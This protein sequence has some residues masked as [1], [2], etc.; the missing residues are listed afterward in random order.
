M[1][2]LLSPFEVAIGLAPG[3]GTFPGETLDRLGQV[4]VFA[5][6][7]ARQI[8]PLGLLGIAGASNMT[9]K[10]ACLC[11][12]SRTFSSPLCSLLV[13]IWDDTLKREVIFCVQA[14]TT[15]PCG[16]PRSVGNS[17]PLP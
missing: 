16:V 13:S 2:E 3:D 14:V 17:R 10:Y 12:K 7:D 4:F 8:E 5:Q 11:H 6:Q 15:A 9:Y 1:L